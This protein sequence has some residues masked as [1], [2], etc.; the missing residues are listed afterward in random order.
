MLWP[1]CQNASI[2]LSANLSL[3]AEGHVL[4]SP[5]RVAARFAD[6]TAEEVADL[7]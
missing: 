3:S 7:W 6:L 2:G 4:I 5:R 1:L